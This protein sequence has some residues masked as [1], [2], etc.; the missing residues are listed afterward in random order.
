M[1]DNFAV[2]V[3]RKKKATTRDELETFTKDVRH[4][5]SD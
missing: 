1:T 2:S 4:N 5:H 3:N